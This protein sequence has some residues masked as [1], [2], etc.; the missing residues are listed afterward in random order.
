MAL[1]RHIG[2]TITDVERSL[3]FYVDA[4]GFKIH[5]IADE[6]GECIDNFSKLKDIDVKT[7]KMVDP[8]NNI[9][10]LLHYRSHPE[11]PH[12]N[13]ERRLSEIG[14][15]HFA[16]TVE[17]LDGLYER[18]IGQGIEFNYPIQRS[19]DNRVKI[20]FCQDPDGTYIELV[21]EL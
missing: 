1:I 19:P 18:L 13:R 11:K 7:I 9:L 17:D 3:K 14:C 5:K 8:N 12:N 6:S 20:A 4:L 10:E 16:L 15:S 2:V 21:E